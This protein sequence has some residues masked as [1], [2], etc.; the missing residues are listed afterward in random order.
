MTRPVSRRSVLLGGAAAATGTAAGYRL[1]STATTPTV[2]DPLLPYRQHAWNDILDLD[3]HG[4]HTLPAH[5]R[6]LMWDL[7]TTPGS[8]DV[9]ELDNVFASIE[10][11]IQRGPSGVVFAVGWGPCYFDEYTNH[12]GILPYPARLSSFETPILA[13]YDMCLHLASDHEE[14]LVDVAQALTDGT[15]PAR[16]S[17]LPI[18]SLRL[19][20]DR[21]G[22]TGPGL[23][24]A[25][26][27]NVG[28]IP[29]TEP[30]PADA[31]LFMGFKSGFRRNQASED[32]VTIDAGPLVGATTMH[33]SHMRL[34]LQSWYDLLDDNQRASRMFSPQAASD[35]DSFTNEAPS[36]RT[37]AHEAAASHGIVGH[38]Q[39]TA[40]ARRDS[41]PMILRRDFSTIDGGQAGLH[42][43]SL[44]RRIEDFN[45]TRRAMNGAAIAAAHSGIDARTNNGINEFIL[46]TSRAN[47]IIPPRPHRSFP[48]L[49]AT[50]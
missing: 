4:N 36:F 26:Q 18:R 19:V 13:T 29:E 49:A 23:P 2:I 11:T 17:V 20:E 5:H 7:P 8:A 22:F 25:R 42:F 41:R 14:L 6:L 16:E 32:D 45:N 30:V 31:P 3:D 15:G 21:S 24:A 12:P 39:T 34:R 43:V 10:R 9:A 48:L 1:G 40:M 46:V 50:S 28:G 35:V 37:E 47:F 44:Q 33:V 38:L 27:E